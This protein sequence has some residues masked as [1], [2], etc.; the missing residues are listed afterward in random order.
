MQ[1]PRIRRWLQPIAAAPACPGGVSGWKMARHSCA[2]RVGCCAAVEGSRSPARVRDVLHC[3]R[4]RSDDPDVQVRQAAY[5]EALRRS[6]SVDLIEFGRFYEVVRTRP[7]CN[8]RSEG[9][10]HSRKA[11]THGAGRRPRREGS[12]VSLA[13]HSLIDTLTGSM[14]AAVVVPNDSDL[15]SPVAYARSRIPVGT[16]NPHGPH[17]VAGKLRPPQDAGMRALV[18]STVPGLPPR[19]PA[20]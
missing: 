3:A 10:S 12:D 14:D 17:P 7:L 1:G 15:A 20:P 18:P 4:P 19:Q 2:R 5:L 6:G 11:H 16:I 13:S 8:S 9:P